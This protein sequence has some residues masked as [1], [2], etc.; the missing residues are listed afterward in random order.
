M[1]IFSLFAPSVMPLLE[2]AHTDI[3]V[4][5]LTEEESKKESKKEN[6]KELEEKEVYI[7]DLYDFE[8]SLLALQLREAS[9]YKDG[10]SQFHEEINLP[11][12]EHS[13]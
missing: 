1:V 9:F 5:D 8:N 12:P 10:S 13:C 6:K 3:V 2:T 4:I 7:E 11:P